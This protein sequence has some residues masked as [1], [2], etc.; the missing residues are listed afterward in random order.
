MVNLPYVMVNLKYYFVFFVYYLFFVHS[1]SLPANGMELTSTLV[2]SHFRTITNSFKYLFNT[3]KLVYFS[4]LL[5][6]LPLFRWFLV[7]SCL[8]TTVD[9][10]FPAPAFYK[11]PIEIS[12]Q[13]L[14]L[15]ISSSCIIIWWLNFA[16]PVLEIPEL[17]T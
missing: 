9:F 1:I 16:T 6:L 15:N 13:N 5:S 4:Q 17:L 2:H 7:H 3:L 8:V 11:L 14:S 12:F 10:W